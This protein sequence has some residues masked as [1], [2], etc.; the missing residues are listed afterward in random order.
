MQLLTLR[1]RFRSR[2][3]TR[4]RCGKNDELKAPLKRHEALSPSA[5]S[6]SAPRRLALLDSRRGTVGALLTYSRSVGG[7]FGSVGTWLGTSAGS[8]GFAAGTDLGADAR[9]CCRLERDTDEVV[10]V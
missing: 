10:D 1:I 2:R 4:V 8:S 3:H 7:A 6:K 5:R 9:M